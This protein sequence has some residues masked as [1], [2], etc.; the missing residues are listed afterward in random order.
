VRW[1][2][3][4]LVEVA[5]KL[6]Q[7]GLTKCPV[8]QSEAI[9]AHRHPVLGLIGG[10]PP[11]MSNAEDDEVGLDYLVRVECEVCGHVLL[12]DAERFRRGD[13][14]I[15]VAGISDDDEEISELDDPL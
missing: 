6:Q 9:G 15:L 12:F 8:C 1:R 4:F 14:P 3:S 13:S 7:L 10:F 5:G 2:R 11:R